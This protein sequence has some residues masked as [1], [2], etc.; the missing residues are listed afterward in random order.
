MITVVTLQQS[1]PSS[2]ESS[3]EWY[4]VERVVSHR[5]SADDG[6]V[7]LLVKWKTYSAKHNTW[8]PLEDFYKDVQTL[9]DKY[10]SK[11]GL[12]V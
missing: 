4:E 12:K 2:P 10:F 6:S 11:V 3:S 5:L 8:E 7:E 9:V 1:E